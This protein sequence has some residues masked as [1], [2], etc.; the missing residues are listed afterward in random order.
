MVKECP[1][2]FF[3]LLLGAVYMA[4]E[5]PAGRV[6]LE[7]QVENAGLDLQ[8]VFVREKPFSL[9]HLSPPQT[10]PSRQR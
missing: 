7:K 10:L 5:V 4:L 6:I 9:W 2:A 3:L 1:L 8:S